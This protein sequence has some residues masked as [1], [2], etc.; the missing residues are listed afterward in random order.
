MP[1]PGRRIDFD[2]RIDKAAMLARGLKAPPPLQP[3]TDRLTEESTEPALPAPGDGQ[4]KPQA[5]ER[6]NAAN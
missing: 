1:V 3:A 2:R 5:P 4:G 6:G